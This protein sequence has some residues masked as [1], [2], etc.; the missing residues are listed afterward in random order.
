MAG[1]GPIG[2]NNAPVAMR[3]FI[4]R[5]WLAICWLLAAVEAPSGPCA[6]ARGLEISNEPATSKSAA[7]T[8]PDEKTTG[9]LA[10]STLTPA[11]AFTLDVAGATISGLDFQGTVTITAPN[12]TLRNC[13]ITAKGWAAL[14]IRA[15]GVTLENCEIDGQAAPGIRGISVSGN[16]VTIRR[17]DIHHVED[18]I[19]LTGSSR[20][21]IENNYI[22]DLQSQWEDPHFDGIATD[23]GTSD[24]LIRGNT[25]INPHP[26]TS[27]IMLSNYFGPV[28]GVRVEGNRLVGGG[29]TV[30]ADGQF[31]GGEISDVSFS[32]NRMGR[33][34]YG[35][36][37]IVGNSP[38]WNGNIDDVIGEN[39]DR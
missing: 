8:Y 7:V 25:V 9:V 18:G 26:Q 27:S 19:Y 24:V 36:V 33:G 29:Y 3:Y 28:S 11:A 37:S 17:C 6:F 2:A 16:N 4:K 35:Y 10:G 15:D 21:D 32:N 13:R 12:V 39:I 22:H 20:I 23:G 5:E 1:S 30:Y 34:H 14:D 38:K 31:N